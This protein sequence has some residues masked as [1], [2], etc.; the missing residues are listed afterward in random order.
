MR[1]LQQCHRRNCNNTIPA[2]PKINTWSGG[3]RVTIC[4]HHAGAVRHAYDFAF[5]SAGEQ[6]NQS[7]TRRCSGAAPRQIASP[8]CHHPRQQLPNTAP[9]SFPTLP[10]LSIV[11][12]QARLCHWHCNVNSRIAP[13]SASTKMMRPHLTNMNG[14][15]SA[16][17]AAELIPK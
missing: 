2:R 11:R 9:S 17:R 5:L 4:E 10:P 6:L 7:A 8:L 1:R 14:P 13:L 12:R 15:G 3:L 16:M